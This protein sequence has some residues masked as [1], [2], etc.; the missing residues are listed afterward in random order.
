MI[1]D[2]PAVNATRVLAGLLESRTGQQIAPSRYWRIQTALAPVLKDAGIPDLEAMVAVLLDGENEHLLQKS[3]EAMLNNESFFFRDVATFSAI[4][5]QVLPHLRE[6]RKARRAI[7]IW[8]AGCSTGQ[9]PLSLA[10]MIRDD[11]AVWQ[12][13]NVEIVGTDISETALAKARSGRFSQFEIQRGLSV[14]LMLKHFE[15]DGEEWIVNPDI[16]R[17]VTF[18]QENILRPG[19]VSGP[20]D[21]V[22]CRN[23]L[24]YFAPETRHIAY[25][26]IARSIAPDG[27]LVLGS[28]ETVIGQTEIF[29]TNPAIRGT[30]LPVL[31]AS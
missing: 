2:Q 23:V 1:H 21:L 28:A 31:Q 15:Q 4:R 3:L 14:D 9:E 18:K 16:H 25:S 13:W 5:G 27:L 24:M 19:S 22:L 26:R 11:A 8:C 29:E 6:L 10:M 20:F 17:L 30:Y 7:R 12:G